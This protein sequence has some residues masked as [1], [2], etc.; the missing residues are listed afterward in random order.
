MQCALIAK[1]CYITVNDMQRPL[2]GMALDGIL[3]GDGE[4]S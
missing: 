3:M 2:Y 1:E 4:R